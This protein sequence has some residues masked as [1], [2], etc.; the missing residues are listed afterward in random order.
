MRSRD[1][2]ALAFAVS[3]L[4]HIAAVATS[5]WQSSDSEE[6]K[7][8]PLEAHLLQ[9]PTG[10]PQPVEA[11]RQI[12]KPHKSKPK[13]K[14]APALESPL[15]DTPVVQLPPSA[16]IPSPPEPLASQP[17]ASES[18][19][20]ASAS[21]P[22]A[23]SSPISESEPVVSQQS[24]PE[25]SNTPDAGK[26]SAAMPA[27]GT[28]GELAPIVSSSALADWPAQGCIKYALKARY[29][30][31][32]GEY[33]QAEQCWQHDKQRYSVTLGGVAAVLWKQFRIE[34]ESHGRIVNGIL[35]ADVFRE[36]NDNKD[37]ETV[38][39]NVGGKVRQSRNGETREVLTGGVALD[40]LSLMHLLSMQPDY[41]DAFDMFV[42]AS[43]GTV[44]R[45][46]VMQG[47]IQSIALPAGDFIARQFHA[48]AR[49]GELKIDVWIARTLRN[50]PVRF[51]IDNKGDIVDFQATD[52]TLDGQSL[53]HRPDS[54]IAPPASSSE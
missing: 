9:L 18:E 42:V 11:K 5:G 16:E 54:A 38:F 46:T 30:I 13:L 7:T 29:G 22:T 2:L 36:K 1:T 4:L 50:A 12:R 26:A 51:R 39:D 41:V 15:P 53:A 43:R 14:S 3:C 21:E 34:Q 37:Y 17:V 45:V 47:P 40:M 20:L 24:A 8:P 35:V 44:N 23:E 6:Q 19:P 32:N 10:V 49:N 31:L 52:I 27:T 33:G 48:E 28:S 25:V